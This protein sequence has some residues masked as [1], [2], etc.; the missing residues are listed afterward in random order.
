[1]Y[2]QVFQSTDG[3]K[4]IKLLG[5]QSYTWIFDSTGGQCLNPHVVLRSTEYKKVN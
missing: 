5:S 1:M 2:Q 4:L 3:W